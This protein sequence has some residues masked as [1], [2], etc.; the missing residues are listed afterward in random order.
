[1]K[2]LVGDV[3]ELAMVTMS[4]RRDLLNTPFSAYW[5]NVELEEMK[6][7]EIGEA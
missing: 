1:V 3:V 7:T 5:W 6:E 4:E 2:E